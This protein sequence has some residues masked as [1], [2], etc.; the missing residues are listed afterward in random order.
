[1]QACITT[2]QPPSQ[3]SNTASRDWLRR[4]CRR[5]KLQRPSLRDRTMEQL[6]AD[7]IQGPVLRAFAATLQ[8]E[9]QSQ[10]TR[11]RP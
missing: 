6:L 8:R 7:R 11:S 5:L 9:H 3:R 10:S 4:A 1:M 2:S